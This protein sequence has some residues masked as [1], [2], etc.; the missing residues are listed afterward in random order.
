ME[1]TPPSVAHGFHNIVPSID[2]SIVEVSRS[3]G[4]MSVIPSLVDRGHWSSNA[5]FSSYFE[6]TLQSNDLDSNIHATNA[7]TT[8]VNEI[9]SNINS[10]SVDQIS[11][12]KNDATLIA[13]C[14][15][16]SNNLARQILG[17]EPVAAWAC[18]IAVENLQ[19]IVELNGLVSWTVSSMGAAGNLSSIVWVCNIN[20]TAGNLARHNSDMAANMVG[21]TAHAYNLCHEASNT[22]HTQSNL[23]VLSSNSAFFA[24][25]TSMWCSNKI[26]ES[27]RADSKFGYASNTSHYSSNMTTC[28]SARAY[29]GA[30]AMEDAILAS[31]SLTCMSNILANFGNTFEVNDLRNTSVYA[32]NACA[33]A[34][35]TSLISIQLAR[36]ASN[37]TT[38]S[39]DTITWLSNTYSKVFPTLGAIDCISL[40]NA[41]VFACNA[42]IWTSNN[43]GSVDVFRNVLM[44]GDMR[45]DQRNIGNITSVSTVDG[46]KVIPDQDGRYLSQQVPDTPIASVFTNSVS[47]SLSK[48]NMCVEFLQISEYVKYAHFA[49]GSTWAKALTASFWIK[50]SIPNTFSLLISNNVYAPTTVVEFV[51]SFKTYDSQTWQFVVIPI[52]AC[53][54]AS[55]WENGLV[56]SISTGI[57]SGVVETWT[58]PPLAQSHRFSP[59]TDLGIVQFN[60]TGIQLE[61]GILTEFENLP[62]TIIMQQC[63]RYFQKSYDYSNSIGGLYSFGDMRETNNVDMYTCSLSIPMLSNGVCNM[64]SP[65]TGVVD[66]LTH[67][68][69]SNDQ[70]QAKELMIDKG[71]IISVSAN[72]T[73]IRTSNLVDGS[74]I[75]FHYTI[76]SDIGVPA[77]I[78]SDDAA[79]TLSNKAYQFDLN[80]MVVNASSFWLTSNPY[81]NASITSNTLCILGSYRNNAYTVSF[82]G[83]NMFGGVSA[84]RDFRE[85]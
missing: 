58:T 30:L 15:Y 23:A 20:E 11:L 84:S 18:N 82:L 52:P 44:N 2:R 49:L 9:Q 62:T 83:S 37:S 53:N 67:V 21:I 22:S 66:S 54:I 31:N 57:A 1:I 8:S 79:I 42:N 24:S 13:K 45:I 80:T 76:T 16:A 64:Y 75:Q 51:S 29:E 35:H 70:I 34:K 28:L 25:N 56:F 10:V 17:V 38:F 72:N 85:T 43:S 50:S 74:A 46:W 5:S 48:I 81:S 12:S 4:V 40:S 47:I 69:P 65:T 19:S 33:D 27:N 26:T 61:R 78:A 32:C 73:T 39:K 71:F 55:S 14:S 3:S 63:M 6:A 36:E 7:L 68:Y 77:R 41:A 60:V 59:G